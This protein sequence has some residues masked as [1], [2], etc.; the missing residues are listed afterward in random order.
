[1]KHPHR[2]TLL[3]TGLMG[4]P[5]ARNLL[6]AGYE[7]TVWNRNADRA[8]PLLR[9]GAQTAPGPAQAI[10][11]TEVVISMLSDGFATQTLLQDPKLIAALRPGMT[12]IDM[13]SA[14]PEH[15]RAQAATLAGLGV[16]HL[17][18]P[19][20]GGTS[21]AAAASLAIMAGGAGPVFEAM[22]PVLETLGRPTHVGPSG[23]GQLCKLANQAIVAVTIAAVAEATLLAEQGGADPAALRAALSGGFADSVI[24]QQHGERMSTGNFAP[25]GP[26]K[27]Q[28]KDLDNTLVEAEALGLKLPATR[29]VRDRFAYFVDEMDG[30]DLD[31]AGLYLELKRQNAKT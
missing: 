8:A 15:A 14:K 18:A 12:W 2:I 31:H 23:A 9:E 7:L 19:V 25:G 20:S 24:L 13:S 11:G 21:G 30:G 5:M 3:G 1:M 29:A 6:S 4:T 10:A 27:L 28:L 16:A 26:S 17:D 22:R